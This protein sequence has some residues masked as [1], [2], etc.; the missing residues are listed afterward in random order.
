MFKKYTKE[1]MASMVK[2]I[3]DEFDVITVDDPEFEKAVLIIG[4]WMA[5]KYMSVGYRH[6]GRILVA[7][8]KALN[9]KKNPKSGSLLLGKSNKENW[10][11]GKQVK[12]V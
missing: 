2:D 10:K 8:Y 1:E 12:P 5:S 3:M 4:E 7:E 11:N 9:P 6:L